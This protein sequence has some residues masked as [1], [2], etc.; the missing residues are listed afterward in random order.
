MSA[1]RNLPLY[2]LT[3]TSPRQLTAIKADTGGDCAQCS[4]FLLT[5]R[6]KMKCCIPDLS[7]LISIC[8][9]LGSKIAQAQDVVGCGGYIKSSSDIDLTKIQVGLYTERGTLKD[10][11]DC[12]PTSGYFFIPV[13]SNGKYKLKV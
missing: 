5:E 9:F 11:T 10:S 7:P 6:F 3:L 4:N 13:Y 12:A 1:S 2:H 8:I